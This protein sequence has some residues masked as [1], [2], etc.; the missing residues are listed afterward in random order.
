M[1]DSEIAAL[2][3]AITEAKAQKATFDE[4]LIFANK[5]LRNVGTTWERA[6]I[7]QKVMVQNLLFPS[8]LRY[9]PKDGFLNH[10]NPSLFSDW[11]LLYREK[12]C[13]VP[14]GI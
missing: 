9:S 5:V 14:G 12:T 7:N 10:A 3:F 4:L 6:A 1:F 13:C 8:G 11:Q 2:E